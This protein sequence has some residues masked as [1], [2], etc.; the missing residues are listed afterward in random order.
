VTYCWKALEKKYNF[1]SDLITIEGLHVKL[2]ASK[3]AGVPV[4]GILGLPLQSFGTKSHLDVAPMENYKVYYKG[5]RWSLPPSPS[6]DESCV[7]ELHVARL[8][9]KCH[10]PILEE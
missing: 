9:T 6:R 2:R 4:V 8:S 3:V 5:G 1:L 10:N 7:S